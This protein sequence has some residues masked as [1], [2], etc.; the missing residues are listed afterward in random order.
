MDSVKAEAVK[1]IDKKCLI[2]SGKIIK[3]DKMFYCKNIM[4]K[5]LFEH[6]NQLILNKLK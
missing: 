5:L 1:L 4:K 2:K 6:Q 3:K